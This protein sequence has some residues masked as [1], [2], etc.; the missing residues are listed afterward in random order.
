TKSKKFFC[1]WRSTA[2]CRQRSIASASRRKSSRSLEMA[3]GSVGFIGVG[4]MGSR[5]ARRLIDKG[6]RLTVFD[7]SDAAVRPFVELG[8]EAAAS[9]VAVASTCEI[10]ITCLPTPSVVHA[11][12]LGSGGIAE[13][14]RVKI[15][16][17][18]STT[19]ATYAKRIAE[20]LR[21]KGIH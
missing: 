5:L 12:A 3:D 21:R 2:A 7:T 17:D 15:F 16:I 18:M 1:R 4:R 20:G 6:H 9:P 8:A 19:G 10:V 11:V 13:G 14:T